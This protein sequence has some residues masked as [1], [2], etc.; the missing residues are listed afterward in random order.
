MDI[1]QTWNRCDCCN[2]DIMPKEIVY[3]YC[4][5]CHSKK[6]KSNFDK[7]YIDVTDQ[8]SGSLQFKKRINQFE[9][10][11]DRLIPP[12]PEMKKIKVRLK[13]K[14]KLKCRI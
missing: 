13:N 3:Q 2:R 1:N 12:M 10:L 14:G 11:E 9:G 6:L 5:D 4:S 8:Y 7:K